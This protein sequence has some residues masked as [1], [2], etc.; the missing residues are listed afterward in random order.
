MTDFYEDP[1]VGVR[2]S[3]EVLSNTH[4]FLNRDMVKIIK[5]CETYLIPVLDSSTQYVMLMVTIYFAHF[6]NK[7]TL[8]LHFV[9]VFLRPR[10][11]SWGSS[12]KCNQWGFSHPSHPVLSWNLCKIK[13]LQ[14]RL[15]SSKLSTEIQY[16]TNHKWL[17]LICFRL[18]TPT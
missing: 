2:Q 14:L 18:H 5:W 12:S 9:S 8:C 6:S 11:P 4:S 16:F 13:S 1:M 17:Y 15:Q 3:F 10:L 7:C